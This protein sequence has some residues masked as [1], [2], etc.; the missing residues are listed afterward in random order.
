MPD[1]RKIWK[2]VIMGDDAA[3]CLSGKGQEGH[4]GYSIYGSED[5]S[6]APS[7]SLGRQS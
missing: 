4:F 1:R 5:I 7:A 2:I 3:W 6:G